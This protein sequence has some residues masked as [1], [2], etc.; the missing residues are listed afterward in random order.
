MSKNC[1]REQ[2]ELIQQLCCSINFLKTM[3]TRTLPCHSQYF[4]ILL[5]SW[6][7]FFEESDLRSKSVVN[8]AKKKLFLPKKAVHNCADAFKT[9]VNRRSIND[10]DDNRYFCF[11]LI[12]YVE[13]GRELEDFAQPNFAHHAKGFARQHGKSL[14]FVFSE[15]IL[16]IK[17]FWPYLRLPKKQHHSLI[18]FKTSGKST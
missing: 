2:G 14:G 15:T 9:K 11:L 1:S 17:M 4:N 3:Y 18:F 6:I 7:G 13:L 8:I 10:N 16:F 12:F 5:K